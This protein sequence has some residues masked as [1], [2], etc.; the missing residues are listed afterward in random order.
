MALGLLSVGAIET[1]EANKEVYLVMKLCT[2]GDLHTRAPYSEKAVVNIIS[3]VRRVRH[4]HCCCRCAFV[5]TAEK[6]GLGWEWRS[7]W[8]AWGA[9]VLR[10][11]L[12]RAL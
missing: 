4:M 9:A 6:G 12:P 8:G 11:R 3:K 10:S 5:R 7:R 2:G 1:F